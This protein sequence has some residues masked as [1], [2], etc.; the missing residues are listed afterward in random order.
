MMPKGIQYTSQQA[1]EYIEK[2]EAITGKI[3]ELTDKT[4]EKNNGVMPDVYKEAQ[5]IAVK[6]LVTV[7]LAIEKCMS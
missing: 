4:K 3:V 2:L 5:Q 7:R 6:G 1:N